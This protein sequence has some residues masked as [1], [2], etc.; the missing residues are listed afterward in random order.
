MR[1]AADKSVGWAVG[2]DVGG[3]KVAAGVVRF[4]QG[5]SR[6]AFRDSDKAGTRQRSGSAGCR[7]INRAGAG[8]S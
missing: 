4:P 5:G 8:G 2:I 3:T 7:E 6:Q 1:N